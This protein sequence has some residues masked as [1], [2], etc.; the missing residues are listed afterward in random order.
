MVRRRLGTLGLGLRRAPDAS[1]QPPDTQ[2]QRAH[3]ARPHKA[4][5]GLR[6]RGRVPFVKRPASDAQ[7]RK[8][9]EPLQLDVG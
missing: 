7:Q 2:G 3:K 5:A 8:A 6:G 4:S 1:P 9:Q